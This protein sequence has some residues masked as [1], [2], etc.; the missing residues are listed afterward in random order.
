[1][2]CE[3]GVVEVYVRIVFADFTYS[4]GKGYWCCVGWDLFTKWN[5]DVRMLL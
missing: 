3:D 5:E 4:G 2:E 1:M